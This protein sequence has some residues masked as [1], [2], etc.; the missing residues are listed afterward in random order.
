MSSYNQVS[1]T[2]ALGETL[3]L[4]VIEIVTLYEEMADLCASIAAQFPDTHGRIPKYQEAFAA[5]SSLDSAR[6]LLEEP[7]NRIEPSARQTP[8]TATVGRQ[9]RPNRITSQRVRLGNAVAR[10]KPVLMELAQGTLVHDDAEFVADLSNIITDLQTVT[11]PQR[12][13]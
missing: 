11:F 10:L 13:G 1:E 4:A 3:S 7:M 5:L 9:T 8:V 6:L 2:R 12:Y